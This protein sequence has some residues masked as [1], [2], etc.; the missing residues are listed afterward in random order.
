LLGP[1]MEDKVMPLTRACIPLR[2]T[3]LETLRSLSKDSGAPVAEL[4]RRAIDS[5]LATRLAGYVPGT[6]LPATGQDRPAP[7][8]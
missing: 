2:S 1:D 8:S 4:I 7:A 6:G 3:Q 5:Y